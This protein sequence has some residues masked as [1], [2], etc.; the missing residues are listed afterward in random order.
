M[1][2]FPLR[3]AFRLALTGFLGLAVVSS[4]AGTG[5]AAD[6][7]KTLPDSTLFFF[8]IKNVAEL[9]E[10]FKQTSFGQ[11]LGDPAM[12]PL[13]DDFASKV[14]DASKVVKAKL[15]VTLGEL[16]SLPQGAATIAV[17]AKTDPKT[18]V[19]LL[20]SADAGK[21]AEKMTVVMNKSTDQAKEADAK[22]GTESFKGLTL[23]I[24][25]PPKDGDKP[26]PELGLDQL[27]HR[28]PTSPPMSTP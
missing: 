26:S 14:E 18:P 4:I 7:E 13:E 8:K 3:A 6:P 5:R 21:N 17:V 27:R 20:I 9:R 19:A 2:R 25:Q 22:V 10:S 1:T 15:G 23:H 24:I 12:K 11:L 16:F 28:L